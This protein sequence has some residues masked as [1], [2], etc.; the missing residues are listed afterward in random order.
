MRFSKWHALGNAY[1]LV[2]ERRRCTPEDA[3]RLS[4]PDEG[5]GSDGVLEVVSV[6]G[7]LRRGA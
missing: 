3:R 5:I 1:L 2:E 6:D 7:E 4:D